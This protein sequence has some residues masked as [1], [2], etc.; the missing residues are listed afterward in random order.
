[1]TLHPKT[2]NPN[3]E[4][5]FFIRGMNA[6]QANPAKDIA[7]KKKTRKLLAIL[8]PDEERRM[9][10]H[11]KANHYHFWL[12]IR[13]LFDSQAR[14][15]E[16]MRVRMD[17]GVRISDQEFTVLVKK[18][19]ETREA[20]RVISLD[21]IPLWQELWEE[22]KPGEYLFSKFLKPGPAGQALE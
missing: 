10:E 2:K 13:L 8:T 21:M 19:K 6:T 20:I 11:L 18:G 14:E 5:Y 16:I 12:F 9:D 22:A 1:M 7:S 17:S 3:G 4:S 15:T